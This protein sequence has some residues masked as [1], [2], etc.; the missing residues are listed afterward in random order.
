MSESC[1]PMGLSPC[2]RT[3]CDLSRTRVKLEGHEHSDGSPFEYR[4]CS[5]CGAGFVHPWPTE[6]QVAALYSAEYAYYSEAA[7]E[8]GREVRSLKYRFGAWRYGNLVPGSGLGPVRQWLAQLVEHAA[9]KTISFSLGIPL[10]LDKAEPMLDFGCGSGLWLRA[11]RRRGYSSL[12]GYD[13]SV[14]EPV[15]SRLEREGICYRTSEELLDLDI[16]RF[17]VVR[18]EH[19]FEHLWDPRGTLQ[20]IRRVLQPGGFLVMTF[21]SIY[22]W[23]RYQDLSTCP[24]LDH[25]QIPMHLIH[26]SRE[27]SVRMVSEAGFEVVGCRVTRRERFITLAGRSS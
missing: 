26:H 17:R 9:R 7:D 11:M 12:F 15:R 8:L 5:L 6:A 16:G 10:A 27:S 14:N 3:G 13:L 23:Q 22:P 24:G 19:V 21:P 1:T 4:V 2:G 20:A 18:L 25:M